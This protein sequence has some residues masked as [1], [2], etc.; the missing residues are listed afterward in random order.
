[1]AKLPNV[2]GLLIVQ[3]NPNLTEEYRMSAVV[4]TANGIG[5]GDAKMESGMIR[6][7]VRL[8]VAVGLGAFII[9]FVILPLGLRFGADN[10]G[11]SESALGARLGTAGL[12]P[13]FLWKLPCSPAQP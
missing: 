2:F 13:A 6:A 1:V 11:L 12:W 7:M 4:D 5:A 3:I 10:L 8:L 9:L